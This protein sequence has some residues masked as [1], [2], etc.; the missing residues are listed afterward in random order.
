LTKSYLWLSGI[1]QPKYYDK[2]FKLAIDQRI[3][4]TTMDRNGRIVVIPV[5]S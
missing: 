1:K 2:V 5:S 3:V 4:Q